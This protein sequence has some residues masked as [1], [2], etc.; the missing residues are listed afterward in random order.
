[1]KAFFLTFLWLVL[2]ASGLWAAPFIVTGP[3]GPGVTGGAGSYQFTYSAATEPALVYMSVYLDTNYSIRDFTKATMLTLDIQ[4]DSP[5]VQ[6]SLVCYPGFN[7]ESSR[8]VVG[9]LSPDTY[10][11]LSIDLSKF[12]GVDW[13]SIKE[14]RLYG[15]SAGTNLK[16][17]VKNIIF[18]DDNTP[19]PIS[20][21]GWSWKLENSAAL[22]DGR[23]GHAMVRFNNKFW[24]LGGNSRSVYKN[25]VWSSDDGV[26]WTQVLANAPWAA[27]YYHSC[28]VFNNKIWLIGGF[29]PAAGGAVT[30]VW[31]SPDGVNWTLV[32]NTAPWIKRYAHTAATFRSKLWILGGAQSASNLLNDVWSSFD[33]ITWQRESDIW[34]AGVAAHKSIVYAD[35]LWVIGGHG[36]YS[37]STYDGQTWTHSSWKN[38]TSRSGFALSVFNDKLYLMGGKIS[39]SLNDIYSS[40]DGQNWKQETALAPWSVRSGLAALNANGKM[41]I[42]GDGAPSYN[43]EIWSYGDQTYVVNGNPYHYTWGSGY[44]I[45]SGTSANYQLTYTKPTPGDGVGLGIL[46]SQDSAL[47]DL[48]SNTVISLNIKS[49]SPLINVS[50]IYFNNGDPV[51]DAYQHESPVYQIQGVTPG[52]YKEYAFSLANF[53][54]VNLARIKAVQFV[55]QQIGTNDQLNVNRINFNNHPILPSPPSPD[56]PFFITGATYGYQWGSG[57][58]IVSGSAGSYQLNYNRP[59]VGDGAGIGLSL[60][61]DWPILDLSGYTSISLN[62]KSDSPV[63]SVT[64]K[65]F[66]AGTPTTDAYC[67]ESLPYKLGNIDPSSFKSLSIPISS[68]PGVNFSL[69]K[70]IQW[71]PLM[72]GNN[73]NVYLKDI[74]FNN[75]SAAQPTGPTPSTLVT[76]NPLINTLVASFNMPLN[77]TILA[78]VDYKPQ[79]A[80]VWAAYKQRFIENYAAFAPRYYGLIFD[81]ASSAPDNAVDAGD[82]TTSEAAG[83]GLLLALFM[84]DRVTFDK[85]YSRLYD[86]AT[87][88]WKANTQLFAWKIGATGVLQNGSATDADQDIALALIFADT[89]KARGVGIWGASTQN[90]GNKAQ[91]LITAIYNQDFEFF[92]YLRPGDYFWGGRS[93]TN[94]SYFSPAWYR[95]FAQADKQA[96]DW[97]YI[98]DQGYALLAAQPGYALGIAPDWCDAFGGPDS[99]G[100]NM[101]YTMGYDAIRVN[102]RLA[103]DYLWF[104]ELKAKAF[105]TQTKALL[106][107]SKITDLNKISQMDLNGM[108]SQP[109]TTANVAFLG[110]FAV[111]SMALDTPSDLTY[112]TNW[113]NAFNN[114]LPYATP[115]INAYFGRTGD[116]A[117]Q[118]SYYNQSLGL[119]SALLMS[120]AMPNVYQYFFNYGSLTIPA[121]SAMPAIY[122]TSMVALPFQIDSAGG[123]GSVTTVNLT[124]TNGGSSFMLQM[125]NLANQAACTTID[126]GGYVKMAA[127]QRAM[128]GTTLLV[129]FN[130]VVSA[131]WVNATPVQYTLS[132]YDRANQNA[133]RINQDSSVFYSYAADRLVNMRPEA[134]LKFTS[135]PGGEQIVT[136]PY[137]MAAGSS[138]ASWNI[139]VY[140]DNHAAGYRGVL[141]R[142]IS[143]TILGAVT[144]NILVTQNEGVPATGDPG[145]R[146]VYDR[147][148]QNDK[149]ILTQGASASGNYYFYFKVDTSRTPFGRYGV[150]LGIRLFSDHNRMQVNDFDDNSLQTERLSYWTGI[151]VPEGAGSSV[152]LSL[153][154]GDVAGG[155]SLKV[156]YSHGNKV[157]QVGPQTITMFTLNPSGNAENVVGSYRGISF[158]LKATPSHSLAVVLESTDISDYDYYLMPITNPSERWVSYRFQFSD[159]KKAGFGSNTRM[160]TDVLKFLRGIQFKTLSEKPGELGTFFLDDVSFF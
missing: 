152:N 104:G 85:I 23:F 69:V 25:D 40:T 92:K 17:N 48:S 145:W 123:A 42:Y 33:G 102:W 131:N 96:H 101:P 114:Y 134:V 121:P 98:I 54:G 9:G 45:A 122:N 129:T 22:A 2:F 127:V 107:Q 89:L 143:G 159:F 148:D 125:L 95:I 3:T 16:I 51:L 133:Q 39:T 135:N 29:A 49:D 158:K 52:Q 88:I 137:Q 63:I 28:T 108:M 141:I 81:P 128:N 82:Y 24:I 153:F 43:N 118:Y 112:R 5:T 68:F 41:W 34:Y 58:S 67:L 70:A 155:R 61:P 97:Q 71:V 13:T 117:S 46:L 47:V 149:R 4:S 53:P 80:N 154:P 87:G 109:S 11:T 55:P 93:L 138:A 147:V 94:P 72:T 144:L 91:E 77:P 79:I 59:L 20:D 84:D 99:S 31:S 37:D 19:M 124:V 116:T 1:M 151:G 73:L 15:V 105:L 14:F 150:N 44:G 86:P 142:D 100:S 64:I 75:S 146:A 78:G 8:I 30:D 139:S 132:A 27:R 21:P 56:R 7:K 36:S 126:P 130:L 110:M 111:G 119:F 136:Q 160:V 76:N 120:G 140:T 10:Q 74:N 35:R 50:L 18:N 38:L 83:Y 157:G 65:Y 60:T 26:H 12:S 106:A 6:L 32:T 156:D 57:S 90:Y 103:M 115:T 62:V 113:V 66:D